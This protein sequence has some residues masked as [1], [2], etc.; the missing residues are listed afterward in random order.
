M[1]P[2]ERMMQFLKYAFIVSVLLFGVV[3]MKIPSKAPHPPQHM[4]EAIISVVAL[5][6]LVLGLNA[7]RF[8]ARFIKP[9]AGTPLATPVS[10]WFAAGIFSLAMM[11]S[12]AL[13]AL[14]LHLLGSSSKLVG[15]LFACAIVTLIFWNPGSAPTQDANLRSF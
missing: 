11:E 12:C 4:V 8:F 6:N 3:A 9:D 1:T 14:V 5:S 7:Q 2:Q 10:Q 15:I 13:F